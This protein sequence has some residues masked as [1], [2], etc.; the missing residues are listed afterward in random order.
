MRAE[1]AFTLLEILVA[2]LIASLLITATIQ[3]FREISD[4]TEQARG[5]GRRE[6]GAEILLDRLEHEL[7]GTTLVV[8]DEEADRLT[9][10][11]LFVGEDRLFGTNDSDSLRFVT[12]TPARAARSPRHG[13]LR[14]VSYEI[15]T[16]EGERLDLYRFE[17]P[18]P[19][20]MEKAIDP[21]EGVPVAEDLYSFKLRF[22]DE[23]D[24]S[25]L[26]SWDSTDLALLDRMPGAVEITVQLMEEIQDS[27]FE[28]GDEHLR[29]IELPIRPLLR[30]AGDLDHI[31]SRCRDGITL[32]VCMRR[33]RQEIRSTRPPVRGAIRLKRAEVRDLGWN[34]PSPSQALG[35]LK[36]LLSSVLRGDP[37]DKCR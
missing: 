12:Q 23:E 22:R 16:A 17:E 28:P 31:D 20:Q 30:S 2:I 4:A 34:T 29:V 35:E 15:R 24:G 18:L 8:K 9:H 7:V 11:W 37:T 13:G 6:L 26:D 27:E 3:T 33:L 36:D 32:S 1:T 19:D 10:P 21:G 25:W 14:M 5:A